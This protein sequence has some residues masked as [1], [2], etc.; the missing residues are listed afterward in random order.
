[1]CV[2]SRNGLSGQAEGALECAVQSACT[3]DAAGASWHTLPCPTCPPTRVS[4]QPAGG[5]AEPRDEALHHRR[6]QGSA[7]PAHRGAEGAAALMPAAAGAVAAAGKGRGGSGS[8][9]VVHALAQ[10]HACLPRSWSTWGSRRL[11]AGPAPAQICT[12]CSPS[13]TPSPPPP[14][15]SPLV[16]VEDHEFEEGEVYAIDIVISTGEGKPKV[17]AQQKSGAWLG[18]RWVPGLG[19]IELGS[20]G[21]HASRWASAC[22]AAPG[23]PA[24]LNCL[25][26]R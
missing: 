20:M 6:Q 25:P 12:P 26:R 10:H 18:Q 14:A 7:Q 15:R 19:W 21:C 8:R 16:Q 13:S 23:P 2:P 9:A 3:G 11:A 1:M 22:A 24:V 5:R 4:P 17:T